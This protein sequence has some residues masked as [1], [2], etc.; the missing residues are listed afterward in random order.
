MLRRIPDAYF[1]PSRFAQNRWIDSS[2]TSVSAMDER[3]SCVWSLC[4]LAVL[5]VLDSNIEL[6]QWLCPSSSTRLTK[7]QILFSFCSL[8]PVIPTTSFKTV[9]ALF[10]TCLIHRA[11]GLSY[12]H[13]SVRC[14][15]QFLSRTYF[16]LP[17][18][19]LR[20]ASAH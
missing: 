19:N 1:P 4:L 7:V 3:N 17:H 9:T 2:L 11:D 5:H 20:W 13:S 16:F 15:A 12:G 18:P 6:S 8:I 10:C 14:W